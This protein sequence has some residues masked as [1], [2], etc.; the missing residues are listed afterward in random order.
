MTRRKISVIATELPTGRPPTIAVI[1]PTDVLRQIALLQEASIA[2]L[3][4]RWLGLFGKDAPRSVELIC[5][6]GWRIGS[7][8]SLMVG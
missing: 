3:K 1:P 2:D 5:K 6:A 8:N 4:Q 7:R